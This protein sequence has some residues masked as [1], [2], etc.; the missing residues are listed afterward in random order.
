MEVEAV[1]ISTQTLT[2]KPRAALEVIHELWDMQPSPF[3]DASFEELERIAGARRAIRA[4]NATK[5]QSLLT[6]L[7]SSEAL[8]LC[9]ISYELLG[10]HAKARPFYQRAFA[11]D[12]LYAAELNLRRSFEL[13]EYGSSNIPYVL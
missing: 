4:G 9:G 10:D 7:Q 2:K 8:N 5:A 11:K 1:N 3:S 6:D 12:K 13:W